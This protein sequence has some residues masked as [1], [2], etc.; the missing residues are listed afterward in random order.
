MLK[1][2]SGLALLVCILSLLGAVQALAGSGRFVDDNDT[3]VLRKNTHPLAH[4][5]RHAGYAQTSLPMEHMIMSLQVPAAKQTALANLI[6][7]Q[8]NPA[9]PEYHRWLTPEQFGSKFGPSAED[10]SAVTDW[11]ASHGFKVEEVAKSRTWINFSGDVSKVERAFKT[12]IQTVMVGDRLYHTNENDPS[13]PR[14]LSDVVSGVVS[15]HNVPRQPKNKG[16][17]PFAS[18]QAVPNYTVGSSHYLAPGDFATIYNVNPAYGAGL[19][20]SGQSI[21]IVGRTHPSASNWS[22]FRSKMGLPANAPQVIVNGPDPGDQ[23]AGENT[24]ADLDVEWAGAVAKNA[25][26]KFVISKSTYTTDGIDLSAQYVVGN[27]LAPVMSVSFGSC[28]A[29]MGASENAFYNNLWAQA[30]AQGITVLV[31][32]GDS[33]AAGCSDPSSAAGSGKAVNGLASTPYNVAVGGTQFNEGTGTYWNSVNSTSATSALGYIPELAWNESGSVSGGS[34]LWATGGGSS[35]VYGKPAWQAAPGVPQ[36]GR[37]NLPDVSLSAAGHDSYLIVTGGYLASVGGTSASAPSMA[38]LMALLVQKTG[39]RQGNVNVGLYQLANRQYAQGGAGVFHDVVSGNNSVPGVTGYSG[40]AGYD[41]ATG[42]GSVDSYALLNNWGAAA[43]TVA[44]APDFTLSATAPQAMIQGS[45]GSIKVATSAASGFNSA[46]ALSVSGLPTG[47]TGSFAPSSIAAPG[48]GSSVLTLNLSASAPLGTRY[49]TIT[50]TAGGISHSLQVPITIQSNLVYSSSF[51][52]KW[53][54]A[55]VTGSAGKW[56]LVSAGS[57]PAAA[58]HS[59]TAMAQ[60]NSFSAASGNQTRMYSAS[61]VVVPSYAK[62]AT[63]SFW[64]FHD[65]N[66]PAN[67]DRLQAQITNNGYTWYSVGPVVSR[68][69]GT[70]GWSQVSV[71]ISSF[72]GQTVLVGFVGTSAGG[73]NMYLDDVSVTLK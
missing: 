67:N 57:N 13:I 47:V 41:F 35:G 26:V 16:A 71:D 21:A 10:V 20:G 14:G 63:F 12:Q 17:K 50:A 68:Y 37:R 39:Q 69:N 24:E 22:S 58:P 9:S 38:G 8:H 28:E 36:D 19:D 66:R 11:L 72:I 54:A 59:G 18:N 65:P 30:A 7:D 64:M 70:A 5:G 52:D 73:Y 44:P 33:G 4:I 3:V 1:K 48:T 55:N 15:L 42:L 6:K 25:L 40:A 23:G 31:S 46:V 49:L 53:M 43:A 2:I 29:D 60:F 56:S 32:T 27:N 62:S 51:N 61:N 34:G 45:T